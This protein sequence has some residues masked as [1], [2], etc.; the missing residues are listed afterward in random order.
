[1]SIYGVTKYF[2]G[3]MLTRVGLACAAHELT[4][5]KSTFHPKNI[6]SGL[7][8]PHEQSIP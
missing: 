7:H 3:E 5:P 1:M 6:L 4:K 2:G 8:A